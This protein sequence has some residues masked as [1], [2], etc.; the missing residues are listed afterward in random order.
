SL[1]GQASDLQQLAL[2][3]LPAGNSL[4]RVQVD[5]RVRVDVRAPGSLDRPA[6]SAEASLDEGR[7]ALANQ[8]QATAL[9][10]RASYDAGALKLSRLAA[11]WQAA[12]VSATGDRQVSLGP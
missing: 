1:D 8:P 9:V 5:G 4:A 12:T 2:V 7:I 6:L 11:T 10:V 3:F